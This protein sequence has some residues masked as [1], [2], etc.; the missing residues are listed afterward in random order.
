MSPVLTPPPS[1]AGRYISPNGYLQL[2]P[3]AQCS[4]YFATDTCSLASQSGY[5]GLLGPLVTD[6]VPNEKRVNTTGVY[7]RT[8]SQSYL[9]VAWVNVSVW[10]RAASTLYTTRLC[11][12][13]SGAFAWSFDGNL[14]SPPL[15]SANGPIWMVCIAV[16]TFAAAASL[17][18]CPS[19]RRCI[20]LLFGV[21]CIQ[22]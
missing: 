20:V 4:G 16:L 14:S 1:L 6:F 22:V 21:H 11:V 17:M 15:P 2:S 13:K 8:N 9:C 10:G 3:Q 7:Y 18:I 12:Y 5:R 19:Q